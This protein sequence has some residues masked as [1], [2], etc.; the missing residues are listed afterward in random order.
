MQPFSYLLSYL[1]KLELE[2]LYKEDSESMES[3]FVSNRIWNSPFQISTF[4]L[5]EDSIL[6]F[7]DFFF[8]DSIFFLY[9]PS[10][11]RFISEADELHVASSTKKP[12]SYRNITCALDFSKRCHYF[13]HSILSN[14]PCYV[15]HSGHGGHNI[16]RSVFQTYYWMYFW[17]SFDISSPTCGCF[18]RT[19]FHSYQIQ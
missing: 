12:F 7:L 2:M 11:Q 9:F 10:V 3:S 16:S 1:D 14:Q 8:K 15:N 17:I 13:L 18:H 4:E 5:L 6:R 19:N